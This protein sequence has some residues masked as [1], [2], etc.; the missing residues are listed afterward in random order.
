[1]SP[2]I[3]YILKVMFSLYKFSF[4]VRSASLMT[5]EAPSSG[6]EGCDVASAPSL[7]PA[8]GAAAGVGTA[9]TG[10]GAFFWAEAGVAFPPLGSAFPAGA[11]FA[12]ASFAAGFPLSLFGSA[13]VCPACLEA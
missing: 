13:L 3:S 5:T 9:F 7:S 6:L 8:P 12:L 2:R 4:S 11:L 10:V 1:M